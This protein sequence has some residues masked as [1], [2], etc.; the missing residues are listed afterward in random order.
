MWHPLR[1]IYPL[2]A[3]VFAGF[4]LG[5]SAACRSADAVDETGADTVRVAVF[6]VRELTTEKLDAVDETGAGADPQLRAA[7]EIIRRVAPD[8]LI[9]NEIDHGTGSGV[10]LDG[11]AQT[12]RDRYISGPEQTVELPFSFAAP[13]N[14]G[15]LSG[16]DLDRDGYVATQED[17]GSREYGNDAWGYGEYP[18]QYSMAVLSRFPIDLERVRTF[19]EFLWADLPGHH[20]PE[21]FYGEQVSERI[22]LSSKSHWDVPVRLP[23]TTLH[24]LMSHPTPP[25]FDGDEDRNGR[26]NFDEIRF[27]ALYLD[28]SPALRDDRGEAGGLGPDNRFVIGGD[29]NAQ[30]APDQ[31]TYDGIPAIG[32]L[33]SHPRVRESGPWLSA[34]GPLDA[35]TAGPPDF[36]ERATANFGGGSRVDYLLPDTALTILNGGLFWPSVAEDSIGNELA[37]AASDHRLIWLDLV[38]PVGR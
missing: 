3:L 11:P 19:Q 14:T 7:A 9:L 35:K 22:R 32:Q 38:I 34:T 13:N 6:N 15:R 5:L 24:L 29:L 10:E 28:D 21:A 18:G 30:P 17:L 2:G 25:V 33:L 26:R 4:L 36:P 31:P 8:I 16:L 20:L 1:H 12:F 27:W 23:G 37:L